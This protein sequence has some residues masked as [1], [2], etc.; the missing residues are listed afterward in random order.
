MREIGQWDIG[1]S[2]VVLAMLMFSLD[3]FSI[4]CR[5]PNAAR[6]DLGAR[7]GSRPRA[8]GRSIRKRVFA[9]GANPAGTRSNFCV[10]VHRV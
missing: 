2:G 7:D 1:V 3:C 10:S 6:N 8:F 5:Q 4:L 9:A